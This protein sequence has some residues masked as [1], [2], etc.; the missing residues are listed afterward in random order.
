M[1]KPEINKTRDMIKNNERLRLF[2][3]EQIKKSQ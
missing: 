1:S 2:L 3:K